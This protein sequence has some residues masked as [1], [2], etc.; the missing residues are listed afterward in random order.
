MWKCLSR[1]ILLWVNISYIWEKLLCTDSWNPAVRVTVSPKMSIIWL[2]NV[3]DWIRATNKFMCHYMCIGGRTQKSNMGSFGV[4]A[5]GA[6]TTRAR[7]NRAVG[8]CSCSTLFTPHGLRLR[9]FNTSSPRACRF[10]RFLLGRAQVNT[11]NLHSNDS[12]LYNFGAI[13]SCYR[14]SFGIFCCTMAE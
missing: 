3:F 4:T 13:V 2:R 6:A 9:F 5:R 8:A 14:I 11:T 10:Y 12:F 1:S 7:S